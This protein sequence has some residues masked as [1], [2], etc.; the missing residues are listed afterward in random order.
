MDLESRE[1]A[2][3]FFESVLLYADPQRAVEVFFLGLYANGIVQSLRKADNGRHEDILRSYEHL[4][5]V[6]REL[7]KAGVQADGTA[8]LHAAAHAALHLLMRA[9]PDDS[10][11]AFDVRDVE[12]LFLKAWQHL[13]P[14][15][16][17]VPSAE[18]QGRCDFMLK[19]GGELVPVEIKKAGFDF[20]ALVRLRSCMAS[21]GARRGIAIGEGLE[22]GLPADVEFVPISALE[23]ASR[24]NWSSQAV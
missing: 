9:L 8:E 13:W 18:H 23:R 16:T 14:G 1:D 20:T 19:M 17:L 2:L 11:K 6:T 12:P 15:S 10:T 4:D 22:T 3:S 21:Y 5:R 24:A 7:S